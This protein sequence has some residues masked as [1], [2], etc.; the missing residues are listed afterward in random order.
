M[1]SHRIWA[2][3]VRHI[4]NMRHSWDKLSD[5]FYWPAMD[6]ILWGLT[7]QYFSAN[8]GKVSNVVLV[9]LTGLVFWQVVWRSQ[10]EITVNLLE[11]LWC[12]NVVNLFASPLT[13]NEWMA[14]VLVLGVIKML[15]TI[16][17]VLAL[18]WLFYTINLI[19]S[20]GFLLLPFFALLLV[21][22]WWIGLV[23]AG[24][25]FRFG[26]QVQTLAW[27]G[28]YVL[29]PFS[30][31]YFPVE[32]LPGWAQVISRIIPTSYL[33]EGSRK[34]LATGQMPWT[35]L[36]VSLALNIVYLILAI[37]F[38]KKSFKAAKEQGLANLD[39]G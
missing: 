8:P 12:K 20:F 34:V 28:V 9:L 10:Y 1:N 24:F 4:Y 38:F 11:E 29:A 14:A 3:V 37:I 13:I 39:E 30:A 17:F 35:N 33:F 25:I 27:A 15:V 36:L 18:T 5:S 21:S 23:V 7:S 2:V 31:I 6:L 16:V 32:I 26:T 19:S 22:G